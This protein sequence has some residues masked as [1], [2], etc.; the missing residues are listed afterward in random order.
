LV[1]ADDRQLK[2]LAVATAAGLRA[3]EMSAA[4][5]VGTDP[6]VT[7]GMSALNVRSAVPS[8]SCPTSPIAATGGRS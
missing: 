7:G 6:R 1:S 5:L 3:V 2:I 8:I 4:L